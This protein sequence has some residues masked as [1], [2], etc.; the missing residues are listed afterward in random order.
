LT[1][2][3][4]NDTFYTVISTAVPED[5]KMEQERIMMKAVGMFTIESVP[6]SESYPGFSMFII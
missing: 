5:I 1:S 6:V 2:V 3:F 4:Q